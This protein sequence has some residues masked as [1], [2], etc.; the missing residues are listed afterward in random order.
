[1]KLIAK[2]KDYWDFK[3]KQWKDTSKNVP[4]WL[5]VEKEL[6]IGNFKSEKVIRSKNVYAIKDFF[7]CRNKNISTY[8]KI[9]FY[10]LFFFAGI[11]TL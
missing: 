4:T 11:L 9:E 10:T 8:I 6:D 2:E 1:M 5:R 3:L 7:I